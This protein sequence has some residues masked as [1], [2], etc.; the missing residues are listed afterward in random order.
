MY[1]ALTSLAFPVTR[2]EVPVFGSMYRPIY[3]PY[4]CNFSFSL[5]ISA[6]DATELFFDWWPAG[7]IDI[8]TLYIYGWQLLI[9]SQHSMNCAH[10]RLYVGNQAYKVVNC[11]HCA[12]DIPITLTVLIHWRLSAACRDSFQKWYKMLKN[13]TKKHIDLLKASPR[14]TPYDSVWHWTIRSSTTR[15]SAILT[16]PAIWLARPVPVSYTDGKQS[17]TNAFVRV[18]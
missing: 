8:C 14:R 5:I 2:D 18:D 15:L 4:F 16:R 10:F 9:T 7:S 3:H 17:L 6:I 1:I 11:G 12:A 13:H